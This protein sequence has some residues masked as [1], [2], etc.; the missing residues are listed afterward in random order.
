MKQILHFSLPLGLVIGIAFGSYGQ[1]QKNEKQIQSMEIQR[2]KQQRN[3]YRK[4]L[5]VDSV[6]AEHVSQ[7]QDSYK[8][9]LKL[10]MADTSLNE[11]ARR[12]KIGALME[13][14][15]QKLRALLSPA[16]QEKIIP[17]TER[18][19]PKSENTIKRN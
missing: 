8:A 1:V 19:A 2:Q 18:E 4:T 10:V 14:K 15:N 12:A 11:A 17:S 13:A 3:F 6:K 16:Q 5:Q 7:V 9:S